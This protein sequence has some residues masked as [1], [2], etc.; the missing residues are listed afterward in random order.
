MVLAKAEH[1][2]YG[3]FVAEAGNVV[4]SPA[5]LWVEIIAIRISQVQR[6][7]IFK[8]LFQNIVNRTS[9]HQARSFNRGLFQ[10]VFDLSFIDLPAVCINRYD[11]AI[12]NLARGLKRV[13]KGGNIELS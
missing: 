5:P 13:E 7:N 6:H 11:I 9:F 12:L 4:K 2:L 8:G 10:Q 3:F 1:L